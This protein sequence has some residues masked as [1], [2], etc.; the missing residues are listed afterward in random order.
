SLGHNTYAP[1]RNRTVLVGLVRDINEAMATR[2]ELRSPNPRSNTYLVLATT[3][4]AMLDGI[5]AALENN[6]TSADLEKA[7]SKEYGEEAFYL[8]KDRVFRSEKHV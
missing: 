6:K 5:K 8:E 7:I 3:Y 4:M 1:S 2:F